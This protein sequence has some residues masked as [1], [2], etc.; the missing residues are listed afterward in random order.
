[1]PPDDVLTEGPA[2]PLSL[3]AGA[4]DSFDS[5]YD[6]WEARN[7][8]EPPPLLGSRRRSFADDRSQSRRD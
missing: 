5:V 4:P 6:P 1:M 3:G 2:I 7:W 8:V